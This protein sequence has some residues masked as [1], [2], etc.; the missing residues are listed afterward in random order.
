MIYNLQSLRAVAALMVFCH[1]LLSFMPFLFPY[2]GY[3]AVGA[4]GVDIFFVLSGFLMVTTT[5]NKEI[6][7]LAFLANRIARIVPIYWLVTVFLVLLF[8]IGFKPVGIVDVTTE[9]FLKSIGFIPFDRGGFVEPLVSV[10][11]TL[12][13]EM[14]FYAVFSIFLIVRN[15]IFGIYL[16]VSLLV[17]LT[18]SGFW[19][20]QN[21]Y[22]KFYSNPIILEFGFGMLLAVHFSSSENM[23]AKTPVLG[24]AA[25]AAGVAILLVSQL[26]AIHVGAGGEL[27]G[28]T[29]TALWGG[30][31]FLLVYGAVRL[32]LQG[33]LSKGKWLSELGAA[34]YSIYLIHGFLL[35]GSE[36]LASHLTDNTYLF[37]IILIPLGIATSFAAGIYSHHHVEKPLNNLV[38]RFLVPPTG[39]SMLGKIGQE[40]TSV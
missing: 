2:R 5:I 34:S 24:A 20:H 31:A 26:A 40:K 7:P 27:S 21:L 18:V 1:H 25:L 37:V 12:N 15:R 13:Y 17:L 36:K 29:R 28:L 23:R 9:Y 32:E 6:S 10:G 39:R 4:A 19:G 14:F 16:C 38:R 3:I 30:A 11:W 8:L 22:W 33:F 35:H